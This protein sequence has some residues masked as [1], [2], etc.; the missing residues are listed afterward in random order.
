MT[1]QVFVCL[2]VL[3]YS[4][5]GL[6]HR[7]LMK[8]THS[9]AYA[10]AV[11]FNGLTGLFSLIILLFQNNFHFY[12][13]S[14]QQLVLLIPVV[15]CVSVATVCTFKGLKLI[16]V[17]EHTILLTTS[18]VWL[19]IGTLVIL[20][21]R[22]TSLKLFGAIIVLVGVFIA[23][24]RN[25]K[26]VFNT[27]AIYVL[28]AAFLYATGEVLSF[29]ILRNLDAI[30]FMVYTSFFGLILLLAMKPSIIRKLSFYIQPKFGLNIIAVSVNDTL[31]TL[32]VFLAY[33]VGRNALQIGPLM[34]TQTIV[35][36]IL[37]L[38]ILHERDFMKQKIL[39]AVTVVVGTVLLI[40]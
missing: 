37:A 38:F 24:W 23:E 9:D 8:Q 33:Q 2:A 15:I 35:T 3:L 14:V 7:V 29:Y 21:E 26:F 31:A 22:F 34:A 39:G 11:V 1:W 17:S 25:R 19:I 20:Q 4:V 40:V 6:L 32:C 16:E 27:G 13:L 5:N 12:V 28:I 36:V 18:K 10:Q 30:P